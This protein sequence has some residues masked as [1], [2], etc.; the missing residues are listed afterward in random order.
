MCD[1][2]L[3]VRDGYTSE[4]KFYKKIRVISSYKSARC[5]IRTINFNYENEFDLNAFRRKLRKLLTV[6]KYMSSINISE[7]DCIEN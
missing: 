4:K 1:V 6:M 2:L 3:L 7:V 5:G